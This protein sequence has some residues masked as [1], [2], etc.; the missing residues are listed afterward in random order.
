MFRAKK[1]LLEI[2]LAE[3]KYLSSRQVGWANWGHLPIRA[4]NTSNN[5]RKAEASPAASGVPVANEQTGLLPPD[6]V[7][8]L[9]WGALEIQVHRKNEINKNLNAQDK[10]KL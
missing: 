3:M 1:E 5:D 4:E 6:T 8:S 7:E 2:V 10:K 9:F